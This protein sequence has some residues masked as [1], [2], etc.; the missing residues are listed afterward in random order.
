[1]KADELLHQLYADSGKMVRR[2]RGNSEWMR[3]ISQ[4]DLQGN[5][6]GSPTMA[7]GAYGSVQ[8]AKYFST[9][10]VERSTWF[11]GAFLYHIPEQITTLGK[12]RSIASDARY[13]YGISLSPVDVW[14]LIPFSWL[15]DWVVNA[16]DVISNISDQLYNKQVLKY[17]Y[18]MAHT[19]RTT[20]TVLTAPMVNGAVYTPRLVSTYDIKQ[21]MQAT[22][23]GFGLSWDGFTPYQLSI[24][25]ALGLS[26]GR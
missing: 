8:G 7:T 5:T 23:F 26:R 13:L 16:G 3:E 21:R 17:G 2:K 25:A 24:L 20:N 22:P 18:T 12:L 14:N 9:V 15:A 1:M 10:R 11:S 19:V 4:I 6:Y